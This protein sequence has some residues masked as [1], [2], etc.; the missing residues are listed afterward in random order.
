MLVSPT[1]AL[2]K[3]KVRFKILQLHTQTELQPSQTKLPMHKATANP[4][5]FDASSGFVYILNLKA[6][7]YPKVSLKG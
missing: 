2:T 1:L 4:D 5:N 7:N 3:C 6:Q